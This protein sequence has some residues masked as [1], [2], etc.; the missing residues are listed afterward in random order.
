[1]TSFHL[2]NLDLPVPSGWDAE[3]ICLTPQ[4]KLR[5]DDFLPNIIINKHILGEDE[6]LEDV[7]KRSEADLRNTLSDFMLIDEQ[8]FDLGHCHA[9]KRT[10]KF[11]A[12]GLTLQQMQC[13]VLSGN[14]VV[15]F[16]ASDLPNRFE[17][18]RCTLEAMLAGLKVESRNQRADTFWE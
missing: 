1:M 9:H 16:T 13:L 12:K 10:Y 6:T 2:W 18:T 8:S 5:P 7:A 3:N 11:K 14:Q 17:S 15:V 4:G